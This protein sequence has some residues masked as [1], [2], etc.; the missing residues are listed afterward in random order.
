MRH[1]LGTTIQINGNHLRTL[2]D[3]L[4]S[5]YIVSIVRIRAHTHTHTPHVN[6]LSAYLCHCYLSPFP[7]SSIVDFA[8]FF[9]YSVCEWLVMP[10]RNRNFYAISRHKGNIYASRYLIFAIYIH[11]FPGS[12]RAKIENDTN[13]VCLCVCSVC[14]WRIK[15]V[16]VMSKWIF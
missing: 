10:L 13:C 8:S 12:D 1:C 9:G 4:F 15:V 2:F 16:Y 11:P 5:V 14:V 3:C 6:Y 7:L